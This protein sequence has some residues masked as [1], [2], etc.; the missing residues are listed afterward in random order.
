MP[1]VQAGSYSKYLGE[2]SVNFN[3]DGVVTAAYGEPHSLDAGVTP[4]AA[5]TARVAGG[6]GRTH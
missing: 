1:I 6:T 4:D 5:N 3:D 2:V